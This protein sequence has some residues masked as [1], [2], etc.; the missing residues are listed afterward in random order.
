MDIMWKV[1]ND[2][3]PLSAKLVI[4]AWLGL[5]L[6]SGKFGMRILPR[7]MFMS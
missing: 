7:F 4:L 3:M 6:M 1:A 5:I 2:F